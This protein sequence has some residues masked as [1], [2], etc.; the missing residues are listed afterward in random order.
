MIPLFDQ[1]AYTYSVQHWI[2]VLF[3]YPSIHLRFALSILKLTISKRFFDEFILEIV[4]K[5]AL[6]WVLC[7]SSALFNN[8]AKRFSVNTLEM[9]NDDGICVDHIFGRN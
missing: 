5:T 9:S 6:N 1:F 7:S 8:K 3:L 2:F 4:M